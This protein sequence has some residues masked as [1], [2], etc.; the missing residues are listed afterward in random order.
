MKYD[1]DPTPYF[2]P[3]ERRAALI[4]L[5]I[6]ILFFAWPEAWLAPNPDPG[7][8]SPKEQAWLTQTL[9]TIRFVRYK[10]TAGSPQK[11]ALHPFDPNRV[12]EQG[13]RKMGL[14]PGLAKNWGR[15]V[16]KGG[17]FR[18]TEDIRKLYGMTDAW[19]ERLKP[20]VHLPVRVDTSPNLARTAPPL[21]KR[22]CRPLSINAADSAEWER[23]PGIGATLAGRIVRFRE[24]LG[25]FVQVSQVGE[26]YGLRDSVFQMLSPCLERSGP[27]RKLQL[28]QAGLEELGTHPYI[29]YKLARAILAYRTQHGPFQTIEDLLAIPAIPA[30]KIPQWTPYLEVK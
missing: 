7:P 17:R 6:S 8:W 29:G 22:P 1:L 28:N 14:P 26:V 23:L 19:F 15:Y 11:I 12:D 13:L 25:G 16:E 10:R 27:V 18:K 30:E 3:S 2:S 20:F 4:L 24:R 5:G 9:D 21:Q